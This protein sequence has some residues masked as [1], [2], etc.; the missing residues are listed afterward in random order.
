[1]ARYGRLLTATPRENIRILLP[2]RPP[3]PWGGRPPIADRK[4]LECVLWILCSGARGQDLLG[5]FHSP[6]TCGRRLRD[7]EEQGGG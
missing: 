7:W 2:K 3:R 5:E 4:M 1:M 6:P